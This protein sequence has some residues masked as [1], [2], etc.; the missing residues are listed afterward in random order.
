MKYEYNGYKPSFKERV[1]GFLSGRNGT[2]T[3]CYVLLG[4]YAVISLINCFFNSLILWIAGIAVMCYLWFRVLS[5]NVYKRR[6]EN[7]KFKSFWR[8]I[9]RWFK[10]KKRAFKERKEFAFRKC[11]SCKSVLRLP[12]EKGKHNTKCPRCGTAF[13]VKI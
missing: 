8:K 11:P 2:D 13:E 1:I 6:M 12:R 3:I 9:S 7:E 4:T 10:Q 5:R